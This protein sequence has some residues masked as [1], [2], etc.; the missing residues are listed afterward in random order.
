[1]A[2]I[3]LIEINI[4]N[5]DVNGDYNYHGIIFL[6]ALPHWLLGSFIKITKVKITDIHTENID[7][8]RNFHRSLQYANHFSPAD[9]KLLLSLSS[10]QTKK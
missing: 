1:M 2:E 4:E 10:Q 5:V 3:K 8:N 9:F 6:V 7:I